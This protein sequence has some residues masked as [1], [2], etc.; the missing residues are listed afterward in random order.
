ML[1]SSEPSVGI[2]TNTPQASGDAFG[3]GNH[4]VHARGPERKFAGLLLG[5]A[6]AAQ[7]HELMIGRF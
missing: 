2:A 7:W 4:F 3:V 5:M 6:F 1:D